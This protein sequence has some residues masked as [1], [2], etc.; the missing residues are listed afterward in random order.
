MLR[1]LFD[2]GHRSSEIG[3]PERAAAS[4][5]SEVRQQSG[6]QLRL[7]PGREP[8]LLRAQARSRHGIAKVKK[9]SLKLFQ[10]SYFKNIYLRALSLKTNKN[11]KFLKKK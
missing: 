10:I 8:N 4:D 6:A 1:P 7:L 3:D 11:G 9:I 2:R 5:R